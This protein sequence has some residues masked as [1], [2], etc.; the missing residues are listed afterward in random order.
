MVWAGRSA[1]E[2]AEAVR[3][4]EATAAAIAEGLLP[5]AGVSDQ[6]LAVQRRADLAELPLAGVP[7]AVPREGEEPARSRLRAAGALFVETGRPGAEDVAAGVVPLALGIDERGAQRIEAACH[8]VLALKPGR[9]VIPSRGWQ[10]WAAL[11]RTA[12][13]LSLVLSVLADEP[14]L[15]SAWRGPGPAGQWGLPDFEDDDWLLRPPRGVPPKRAGLRVAAAPQ[16]LPPRLGVPAGCQGAVVAAAAR[17][18]EAGHTVVDHPARLPARLVV[19]TATGRLG[20]RVRER[21]RDYGADQWF[22]DADVLLVP[23]LAALPRSAGRARLR[24]TLVTAP[25]NLS[26]WPA[27]TLPFGARP[28]GVQLVAPPGSEPH[29]LLLAAQ[30]T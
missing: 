12:E 13:D 8:G 19:A 21:W 15:A 18:R 23:A 1:I 28:G 30:L 5:A 11:A 9:G 4:G 26:G 20:R 17:L 14:G 2:I 6:A 3:R 7:V 29:L 22:G 16:P 24:D 10:E 27:L 25:W